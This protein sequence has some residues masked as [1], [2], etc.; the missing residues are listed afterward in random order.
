MR[1]YGGVVF[2]LGMH[3][4]RL[5]RSAE[6][7][8]IRLPLSLAQLAD[9][10]D[11]ALAAFAARELKL[12]VVVTRGRGP[13]SLDPTT[14]GTATRLLILSPLAAQPEHLYQR[15]VAVALVP[16]GALPGSPAAG[17]KV[18]N[19]LANLLA[20]HEARR[21]GAYEALLVGPEG[22][23]RE[24]ASSNVFIVQRGRVRTPR[25]EAGILA[26]VTRAAVFE[27]AQRS[28]VPLEQDVLFASDVYGAEECFLTSSLR[29]VVPIV[30]ADGV[31]IGSGEPG[32]VTRRLHACFRELTAEGHFGATFAD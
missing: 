7:V 14:A 32:P 30:C 6:R 18:S 15:G 13:L 27:A 23:L 12:R 10:I 17:A 31:A 25:P 29:E 1:T 4:R 22:Q 9:E 21:G 28:G 8:G 11:L 5:G 16:G 26:G 19:Y 24:G 2:G 20:A 3:L